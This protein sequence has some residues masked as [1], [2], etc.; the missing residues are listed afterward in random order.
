[1]GSSAWEPESEAFRVA[2]FQ[3]GLDETDYTEG[4][5]VAFEYRWA[6]GQHDR[7]TALASDPIRR[8]V[9]VIAAIGLTPAALAAKS[10]TTTIP[11][12]FATGGDPVKLGLVASLNRPGGNLTGVSFLVSM[13]APKRLEARPSSGVIAS[14]ADSAAIIWRSGATRARASFRR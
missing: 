4:R 10:L 12:V 5:N 7:L 14:S 2:A 11:I 6:Q 9:S 13:T 3:K 1:L 8:R